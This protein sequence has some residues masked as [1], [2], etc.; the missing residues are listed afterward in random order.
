MYDGG[1]N[2]EASVIAEYLK[3]QG[4]KTEVNAPWSGQEG[5]M[6]SAD[7]I[8]AAL[9]GKPT[10]IMIELRNDKAQDRE[11][12]QLFSEKFVEA[13]QVARVITTHDV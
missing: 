7:S 12:L 6:Y 2:Y 8:R 4:F 3:I 13:L 5:F 11:W 10:A 9:G 1:A